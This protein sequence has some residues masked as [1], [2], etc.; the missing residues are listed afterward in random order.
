VEKTMDYFVEVCVS[1]GR[2]I[3]VSFHQDHY[4]GR[5]KYTIDINTLEK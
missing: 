5:R 4:S 1:V 3:K 2:Q